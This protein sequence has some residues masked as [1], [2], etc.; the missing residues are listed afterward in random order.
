MKKTKLIIIGLLIFTLG[1]L[2]NSGTNGSATPSSEISAFSGVQNALAADPNAVA[3]L[4]NELICKGGTRDWI[5]FLSA[6]ISYDDFVEYWRDIIGMPPA[7]VNSR[8]SANYCLFL[9]VD[10]LL[11]QVKKAREQVR[12]AFYA[13]DPNADSF[14]KT[15]YKREAELFFLRK[16]INV[17][18]G[19]IIPVNEQKV[20]DQLSA[21][22]VLDKGAFT[23]DEI[24]QLFDQFKSKYA[25]RMQSY[26]ECKD[27]GWEDLMLKIRE[28]RDNVKGGFGIKEAAETIKNSFN[29]VI[30]TPLKRSGNFL[31]GL[32]DGKING[33]SPLQAWGDIMQEVSRNAPNGYS[34]DQLNTATVTEQSRYDNA[35]AKATYLAQYEA[36]YKNSSADIFSSIMDSLTGLEGIITK[37]FNYINQTTQ[38]AKGLLDK[39][40]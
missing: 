33:V 9:D 31:G 7:F 24:K 35:I 17:S 15:Y 34:F 10:N 26:I 13:C 40:C 14:K 2:Q 4:G 6:V 20:Y 39:A 8:Y 23:K 16:Y 5:A 22:Y 37:S 18:S 12:K 28:L 32:L 3:Q 25:A 30:N 21:Y 36:L 1:I 29:K 27:P 38:C 19:T 11:N